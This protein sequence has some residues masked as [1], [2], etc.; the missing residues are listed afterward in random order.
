MQINRETFYWDCRKKE[1]NKIADQ[2]GIA[3][4]TFHKKLKDPTKKL[5]ADELFKICEILQPEMPVLEALA[6]YAEA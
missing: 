4:S 6:Y 2:L 1:L 3:H 5:Y